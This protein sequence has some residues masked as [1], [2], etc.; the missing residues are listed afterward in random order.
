MQLNKFL[1]IDCLSAISLFRH[2]YHI[3]INDFVFL[4]LVEDCA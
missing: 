4:F 1:Q 3:Y 2:Y